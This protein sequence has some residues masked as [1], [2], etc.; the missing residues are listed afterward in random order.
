[1]KK[2]VNGMCLVSTVFS[3][4]AIMAVSFCIYRQNT[5][6]GEKII[7]DTV[8]ESTA[9]VSK[10]SFII[11]V[12]EGTE[13]QKVLVHSQ[14]ENRQVTVQIEGVDSSFYY[15]HPLNGETGQ[16]AKLLYGNVEGAAQIEILLNDYCVCS[17]QMIEAGVSL[18]FAPLSEVYE[19]IVLVDAGHMETELDYGTVINQVRESEI[20]YRL[21]A[22]V[23]DELAAQGIGAFL[24]R[25]Q[26]SDTVT[27]AERE[28]L[29]Q[30]VS[31]EAVITIHC[32]GDTR[33][34]VTHGMTIS[35]DENMSA[36]VKL[37][38]EKAGVALL[39]SAAEGK[40][41]FE[42]ADIPVLKL[43]AGYLTNAQESALLTD[44]IYL[45]KI[46]AAIAKGIAE[47]YQEN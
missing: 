35:G 37:Y 22:M 24:S 33:T 5:Y 9:P 43:K 3:I 26:K 38:L 40:N 28:A 10:G 39:D 13:P 46:S 4:L 47:Y 32:A 34:R 14:L 18:E 12:P 1:M 41:G 17:W 21:A 16:V 30:T 29:L 23:Q 8:A 25:P 19:H 44:E 7:E 42:T 36:Q 15:T 31:A 45:Q 6:A 2:L 11:P 20:N 27:A